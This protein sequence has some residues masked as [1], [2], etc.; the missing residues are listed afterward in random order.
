MGEGNR[1]EYDGGRG[2]WEA[3]AGD[4]GGRGAAYVPLT[5]SL[6]RER[7]P[8]APVIFADPQSVV[9]RRWY[10]HRCPD[11]AA[12]NRNLLIATLPG[13][14]ERGGIPGGGHPRRSFTAGTPG[15]LT[16]RPSAGSPTPPSRA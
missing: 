6:P 15:W 1:Y 16:R 11:F 8:F 5:G 14:G 3:A 12:R 7:G 9:I 10:D 2:A 4:T 13:R